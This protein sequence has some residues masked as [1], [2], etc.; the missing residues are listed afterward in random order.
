MLE[1][2]SKSE[3]GQVEV[4]KKRT[5]APSEICPFCLLII[6]IRDKLSDTGFEL[7]TYRY[8]PFRDLLDSYTFIP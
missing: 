4:L 1:K 3:S 7:L 6:Q 5:I 8:A 2:D